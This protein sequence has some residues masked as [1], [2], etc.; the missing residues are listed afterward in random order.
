[1]QSLK[2]N[3]FDQILIFNEAWRVEVNRVNDVAK[4]VVCAEQIF[5]NLG[6]CF[7]K[8]CHLIFS[9]EGTCRFL[10]RSSFVKSVQTVKNKTIF[11]MMQIYYSR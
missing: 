6:R 7:Y 9:N 11:E 8:L 5:Y 3:F 2:R 10:R 4:A 1:M